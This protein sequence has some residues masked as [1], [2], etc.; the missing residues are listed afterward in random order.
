[1]RVW[2]RLPRIALVC[3]ILCPLSA[4][5][6]ASDRAAAERVLGP[7]WQYLAQRAGMI[8]TGTVLASG[9]AV[10]PVGTPSNLRLGGSFMEFKLRIDRPIAGVERG[11]ILTIREWTGAWSR[12]PALRSG[13]RV[14]LF[15][16]PPSRLGLTSPVGGGRG[17]IR[18]D[19]TGQSIADPSVVDQSV[20][21]PALPARSKSQGEHDQDSAA[22]ANTA[23]V[24]GRIAVS[25]LER[26]IRAARG[27]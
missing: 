11:Q 7:S 1:M 10:E 24:H 21:E 4:A 14:L 13:E 2:R 6:A 3:L 23:A 8:F 16:Y 27:D 12:H 5:G 9:G 19:S 22:V 26:A 17:Q 18:L 20:G 25:Q 15:L